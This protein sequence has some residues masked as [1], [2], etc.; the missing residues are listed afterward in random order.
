MIFNEHNPT[1]AVSCSADHMPFLHWPRHNLLDAPPLHYWLS[2]PKKRLYTNLDIEG[3]MLCW[4]HINKQSNTNAA[5]ANAMLM[6]THLA[7]LLY[8]S[9]PP[10]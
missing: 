8:I 7:L 10:L 2:A 9:I 6:A 5:E 3:Q 4:G 1:P